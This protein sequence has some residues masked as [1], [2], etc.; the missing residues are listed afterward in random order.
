MKKFLMMVA[1]V[2]L[3]LGL[4]LSPAPL[5]ALSIDLDFALG[6]PHPSTASIAYAGGANPLIGT[7]INVI[8]VLG[9]NTPLNAGS[10]PVIH[11]G[12]LSFT[13]GGFT[14]FDT[15][16]WNFDGGG[17]IKVIG[18]IPALSIP[19]GTTLLNGSF[20]GA[21]VFVEPNDFKLAG[22]S[23]VDT[24][25]PALANY[26]GLG[27]PNVTGWVGNFNLSFVV[28]NALPGADNPFATLDS[29]D[30]KSGDLLNDPVPEPA[31]MLLLGSG[32][33][34]MGVYARRRFSKK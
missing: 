25:D 33:L 1:G 17:T 23:F 22:T 29:S 18:G 7:D 19:D 34:G 8:N 10:Q 15:T 24:K 30:I 26:F 9:E 31:T 12:R 16:H 27:L 5:Q 2:I 6:Q 14:G 28:A 21:N 13:T 11:N 32:L 4:A 3:A 20:N